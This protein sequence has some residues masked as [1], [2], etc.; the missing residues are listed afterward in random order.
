MQVAKIHSKRIIFST[1]LGNAIGWY[2]YLLYVYFVQVISRVF[3]PMEDDFSSLV[4]TLLVF[5]IGFLARPLGGYIFGLIGDVIGRKTALISSI[6]LMIISTALIGILPNFQQIGLLSPAL[7]II[8]RLLQGMALGGEYSSCTTYLV[9]SAPANKKGFFGSFSSMSLAL[10]VLV[11][12]ITVL[13]IELTFTPEEIFHYAWRIPFLI[14]I[15]YGM[16]GFYIR[17]KLKESEEFKEVKKSGHYTTTPFKDIMLKH[18]KNLFCTFAIFMGLTI[19]FYVIVVFSRTIMINNGFE[20]KIATLLNCFLVLVYMIC[21]PFAGI[22][23]DK[24][25]ERKILMAGSLGLALFAF[26]F[27]YFIKSGDLKSV[28]FA[29]T[30]G[31]L[32]IGLYQAAVPTFCARCFPIEVRAS[33]VSLSY[34][35]PA[36]IF[37]GTAPMIVTYIM[38]LSSGDAMPVGFYVAFGCIVAFF[39]SRMKGIKQY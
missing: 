15:I 3:F 22:M 19:P 35:L 16:V 34:N 14:S 29:C 24:L 5:A 27:F 9:E 6:L 37:G 32:L 26:P 8:I 12:S 30:I 18:K 13:G 38:K 11:S 4:L 39:G 17:T 10:G 28:I 20:P 31:G 25:G 2:D 36:I 21:V 7:L 1:F 33:G 23:A